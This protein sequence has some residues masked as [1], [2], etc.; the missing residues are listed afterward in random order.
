[1][2]VREVWAQ[3]LKDSAL[4]MFMSPPWFLKLIV[5]EGAGVLLY[6]GGGCVVVAELWRSVIRAQGP[7]DGA[8]SQNAQT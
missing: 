1:M 3:L 5:V 7:G 6:E 2:I 8:G 4:L